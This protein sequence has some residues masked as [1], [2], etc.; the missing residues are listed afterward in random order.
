MDFSE[1]LSCMNKLGAIV[2]ESIVDMDQQGES[3]SKDDCL[4]E[5]QDAPEKK[6]QALLQGKRRRISTSSSTSSSASLSGSP[7]HKRARTNCMTKSDAGQVLEQDPVI[8]SGFA[9]L[10]PEDDGNRTSSRDYG[11]QN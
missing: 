6:P 4:S 5:T 7:Q 8:V 10:T 9:L 1:F 3:D 2:Q 11:K